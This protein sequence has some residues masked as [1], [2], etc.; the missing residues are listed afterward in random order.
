MSKGSKEDKYTEWIT[1]YFYSIGSIENIKKGNLDRTRIKEEEKINFLELLSEQRRLIL[2]P[3]L[4]GVYQYNEPIPE[5]PEKRKERIR[6][7]EKRDLVI[8]RRLS[9]R[10]GIVDN[11]YRNLIHIVYD[12]EIWKRD[13]LIETLN[14]EL[15]RISLSPTLLAPNFYNKKTT[16]PDSLIL[17]EH[18]MREGKSPEDID[19]E[20]QKKIEQKLIPEAKGIMK[21]LEPFGLTKNEWYF[22][23]S[24]SNNL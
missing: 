15:G 16:L 7:E 24:Y 17:K 10:W 5:T 9:E 2:L 20:Q 21:Q 22:L 3:K 23:N 19:F 1:T 13:L 4:V 12:P 8:D 18:E 14:D 11:I 6:I